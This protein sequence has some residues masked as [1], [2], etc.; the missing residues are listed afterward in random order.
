MSK[1]FL[2]AIGGPTASGKT[3]VAIQL[4][5][6]AGGEVISCDSMQIYR[7]MDIGTAKPTREERR[8]I[9]HYMLDVVDP[10]ENYSVSAFSEAADAHAEDIASRGRV[11]VLC[12]GTGL[13]MDAVLKPMRFSE[14]SSDELRASLKAVA[15][16]E[17]GLLMLHE[18]LRQID[19]DSAARLHPNDLRRVIR[20]IEVYELTGRTLTEQMKIDQLTPPRYD[21]V[22]FALEWPRDALYRRINDRVDIMI[23]QGLK[24]EVEALLDS[25]VSLDATSMQGLGYKEMAAFLMGRVSFDHAVESIKQGTRHYAKRQIT[26]FKRDK[27][28]TWLDAASRTPDS[29]SDEIWEVYRTHV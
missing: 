2:V 25:G 17:G 10:G 14:K 29:L 9:P 7:G 1:P 3:A 23:E 26:W 6:R 28:V 4:C 16:Q 24:G 12:G 5:L 8:G 19:P 18:R 11:P 27:T 15:A 13:Y 20:A 21:S 22:Q